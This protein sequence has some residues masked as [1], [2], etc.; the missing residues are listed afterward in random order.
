MRHKSVSRDSF[1]RGGF[2]TRPYVPAIMRV[3]KIVLPVARVARLGDVGVGEIAAFEQEPRAVKLGAG[4]GQAIAEIEP[5]P[6]FAAF[7]VA[8][9]GQGDMGGARSIG[10]IAMLA[11]CNASVTSAST[12]VGVSPEIVARRI[13]ASRT[14]AS[15]K[16]AR[17]PPGFSRRVWRPP[18]LR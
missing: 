8:L 4:V 11:A 13:D 14:T 17:A 12:S 9:D 16:C 10:T 18:A 1:R 2:E 3:T 5:R 15:R 6:A 7:A